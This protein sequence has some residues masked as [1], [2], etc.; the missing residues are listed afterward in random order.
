LTYCTTAQAKELLT[1][2]EA[3]WDAEIVVLITS[4][5]ALLTKLLEPYDL[6]PDNSA[7]IMEASRH[8]VGWLFRIRRDPVGAVAFYKEALIFVDAF[9]KA[10]KLTGVRRG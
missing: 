9:V 3:T 5:D 6:S 8:F 1:I 2:T 10:E 4:A 7:T